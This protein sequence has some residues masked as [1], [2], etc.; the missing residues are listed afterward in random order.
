MSDERDSRGADRL[1]ERDAGEDVEHA[2]FE[3]AGL[4]VVEPETG[5][6]GGLVRGSERRREA[7]IQAGGRAIEA[8]A[9]SA[10]EDRC[11]GLSLAGMQDATHLASRRVDQEFERSVGLWS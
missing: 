5:Q 10:D 2:L 11:A 9:G 4:P 3:I 1:E 6:A 8:A 7:R